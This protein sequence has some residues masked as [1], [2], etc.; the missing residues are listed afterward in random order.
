MNTPDLF[1]YE[2]DEA[3]LS[4]VRRFVSG[5][6]AP[7]IWSGYE[8]AGVP[9]CLVAAGLP[10]AAVARA[11]RFRRAGGLLLADSGAFEFRDHPEDLNW[12]AI[13]A[14][15]EQLAQGTGSRL[16]VILP[17]V[18][19]DQVASIALARTYGR[20][21]APLRA[22]GHELLVPMQ[23]GSLSL[24]A[25]FACY[26]DALGFVPG[27]F[28]I[29][30][31]AAAMPVDQL[32][33]LRD[34]EGAPHRVHFLGISRRSKPLVFRVA[35]LRDFWPDCDI[36]AD[37]CEHRAHVGEDRPITRMRRESLQR[38][39][40]AGIEATDDTEHA[41]WDDAEDH[42]RAL[43]PNADNETLQD[44]VCSGWGVQA[45]TEQLH[46]RLRVE[47][48][49]AATA[50]SIEAFARQRFAPALGRAA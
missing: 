6:A 24:A 33:G 32:A 12:L 50:D 1:G 38:R 35:A 13:M 23:R 31:N 45:F 42:L 41:A 11:Q 8:A 36:S 47:C 34:I 21:L 25:Y 46:Q 5:V 29:P 10:P 37:A 3:L 40:A 43:F 26:V 20:A 49:P 44:L 27:G 18:V 30:S 4:R 14:T 17:D 9:M 19:G 15:Y 2:G 16:S 39:V 48:G 22:A 28:A 7:A